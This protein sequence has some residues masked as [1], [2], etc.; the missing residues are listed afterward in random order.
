MNINSTITFTKEDVEELIKKRVTSLGY[1]LT[2]EIVF[3]VA[4]KP[5]PAYDGFPVHQLETVEVTCCKSDEKPEAP[6]P[7]GGSLRI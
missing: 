7:Y 2:G 1:T 5:S 4:I 6:L 3:R